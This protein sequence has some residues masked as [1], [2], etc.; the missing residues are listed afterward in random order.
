MSGGLTGLFMEPYKAAQQDG[1]KGFFTGVGKGS[2]GMTTKV[3]GGMIV[4]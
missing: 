1:A 3:T 2:L 4:R